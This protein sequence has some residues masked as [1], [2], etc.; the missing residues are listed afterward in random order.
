VRD[1]LSYGVV[2]VLVI[3]T[4]AAVLLL[5]WLTSLT[6]EQAAAISV[7]VNTSI[8]ALVWNEAREE[9]VLERRP[10]ILV[11]VNDPDEQH[12]GPSIHRATSRLNIRNVG[13]SAA[14]NVKVAFSVPLRDQQNQAIM[15]NPSLR[16]GIRFLGPGVRMSIGLEED[17]SFGIG[18]HAQTPYRPGEPRP[19]MNPATVDVQTSYRDPVSGREYSDSFV[20]DVAP[21]VFGWQVSTE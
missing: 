18:L 14:A 17:F 7:I 6:L 4:T 1:L 19:L 3:L 13:K 15:E 12:M 9:R 21:Q 5:A 2:V 11:E 20:L 8:A 16:D 10:F